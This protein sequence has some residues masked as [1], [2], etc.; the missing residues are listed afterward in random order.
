[1]DYPRPLLTD[2][3]VVQRVVGAALAGIGDRVKTLLLLTKGR[4]TNS[5]KT[6]IKDEQ[7]PA[8][9]EFVYSVYPNTL[10]SVG[11]IS[12]SALLLMRVFRLCL[13]V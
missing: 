8:Y 4:C 6:I 12:K 9:P 2:F 10:F 7:W 3:G 5:N 1:M 13:L 11:I